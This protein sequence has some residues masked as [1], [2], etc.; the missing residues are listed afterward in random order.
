[1]STK[2]EFKAEGL[3]Q[4][5]LFLLTQRQGVTQAELSRKFGV[6]RATIGRWIE[7]LEANHVPIEWDEQKRVSVKRSQFFTN[8][9]LSRHESILAMVA[10]RSFQQRQD[11]SDR[12]AVE[13]LQKI[14]IALH[15][16]VA[17]V[18]GDHVLK[19]VE[20]QRRN[21]LDHRSEYQRVIEAI[22]DAW[23][24][25]RKVQIRYR[26]LAARRAFDDVFHPYLLEPSAISRSVYA[27]G[28]SEAAKGV[29]VRKLE[30]IERTPTL[31]DDYFQ[32]IEAFDPLQVLNG[33]WS[34]WFDQEAQ[35]IT[36]KLRFSAELVIRRVSEERWHPS[37][38]IER[39]GEGRLIWTAEIDEVQEM[40]PWIRSWGA[41]CEVLEPRELRD[42]VMGELRRQMR[43]YAI[44]TQV[45]DASKP[46][47][48]LL[49][50]IF[51]E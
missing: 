14:G 27:I 36:V 41:D 45:Q 9:R 33:A 10:L 15:Q 44:D 23:I 7:S 39:D 43:V 35:P 46:N 5:R 21:L 32:A 29:R 11:K 24:D 13:M 37:Q 31:L 4:L 40:L 19:L 17:P 18:A 3:D 20:Q 22:S 26:P 25:S 50:S 30:R 48:D 47:L 6:H 51:G 16:G 38:R 28:Y 34:I 8:L 1:M 42:K 2:A 49:D 12:N